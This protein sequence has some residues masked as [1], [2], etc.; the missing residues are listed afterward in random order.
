MSRTASM[1][2]PRKLFS[3]QSKL[4]GAPSVIDDITR[5]Q[6]MVRFVLQET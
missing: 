4:A 5:G 1:K 3:F 6:D 2:T